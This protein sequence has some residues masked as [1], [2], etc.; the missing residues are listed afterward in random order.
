MHENWRV[1]LVG[2][3]LGA[4][5]GRKLSFLHVQAKVLTPEQLQSQSIVPGS[6]WSYADVS[7]TL[8]SFCHRLCPMLPC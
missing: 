1:R 4:E 8:W 5:G 2:G 7:H 6:L 3:C